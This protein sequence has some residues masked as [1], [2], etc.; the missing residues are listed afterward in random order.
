MSLFSDL[1][2]Q[3]K[4]RDREELRRVYRRVVKRLHPDSAGPGTSGR[5]GFV[6]FDRLK[7]EL[8]E[9]EQ[10][11]EELAKLPLP[12][13]EPGVEVGMRSGDGNHAGTVSSVAKPKAQAPPMGTSAPSP[14]RRPW[15]SAPQA[16]HR[17]PPTGAASPMPVPVS[18]DRGLLIAELRD[19]VA[20]GFPVNAR[21]ASRNKAYRDCVAT[22]TA[23]LSLKSGD[24]GLFARIDTEMGAVKYGSLRLHY[25][26]MQVLWNGLDW[27]LSGYPASR[28]TALRDFGVI[29]DNL[30]QLGFSE[31]DG[32]LAWIVEAEM[33]R[34][35]GGR[36]R[37]S[38]R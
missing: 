12:S 20:R 29:R 15:D 17:R 26:V 22:V 23:Q 14:P 32:L 31:L 13:R 27:A 33:P 3:G 9:A 30:A 18:F 6:D 10:L 1:I 21:A 4:I 34:S 8:G 35:S 5:R 36:A 28:D 11:L 19:L 25:Y 7:R 37:V 38:W 24:S 2:A 16:A